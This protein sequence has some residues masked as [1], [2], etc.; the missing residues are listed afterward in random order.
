MGRNPIR[1]LVVDDHP[2]V[3]A[4]L[5]AM[6]S[7]DRGIA[8]VGEAAN[9]AAAIASVDRLHPEVVLMDIG[10]PD[11]GGLE[12]TKLVKA[13]HREVSVI[14]VTGHDD[15]DYLMEA[16]ASGAAGYL[17]KDVPRFDLIRAVRAVARGE[18]FMNHALMTRSLQ[19][20]AMKGRGGAGSGPGQIATLTNRER[21]VLQRL[22]RGMSN[23]EIAADL[24]VSL[25]TAKTHVE[26]IIQKLGVSDR[27]QA[28]V[29]AVTQGLQA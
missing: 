20:L 11:M 7:T 16:I 15:P 6:L 24:V 12:A 29:L 27:T 19:R 13:A 21:E 9:G 1:V 28:A 8:V 22:A 26:H 18:T 17:L 25:A 4:G 14:M 10:M 5:M 3:R 23:K 2:L